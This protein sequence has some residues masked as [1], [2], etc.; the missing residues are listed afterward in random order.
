MSLTDSRSRFGVSHIRLSSTPGHELESYLNKNYGPGN[1]FYEDFCTYIR[2]A[3]KEDEGWVA[4]IEM[5]G[6]GS[7]SPGLGDS[8]NSPAT[9][10]NTD[11][12]RWLYQTTTPSI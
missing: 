1:E 12:A 8:T 5:D 6:C 7:S 4:T 10:P 3:V 2:R 9:D 11:A